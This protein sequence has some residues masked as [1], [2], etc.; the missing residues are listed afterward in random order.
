[1]NAGEIESWYREVVDQYRS[2]TPSSA[3]LFEEGRRYLPGGDTRF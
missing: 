2:R 3:V 1:M